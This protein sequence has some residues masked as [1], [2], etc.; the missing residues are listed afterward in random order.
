MTI[1][2]VIRGR[3]ATNLLCTRKRPTGLNDEFIA[4]RPAIHLEFE[5]NHGRTA[6]VPGYRHRRLLAE[7]SHRQEMDRGRA[8][9]RPGSPC[10][11]PPAS[12]APRRRSIS[13]R[14]KRAF[15]RRPS[16]LISPRRTQRSLVA[17]L[18]LGGFTAPGDHKVWRASD[19]DGNGIR[20]GI[21]RGHVRRID[22]GANIA[23][24]TG[25][26]VPSKISHSDSV[27]T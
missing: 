17:A 3:A 2:G 6:I 16:G 25:L 26:T 10:V 24:A 19:S 4:D 7:R 13:P 12:N 1:I 20:E 9:C 5:F 11:T 15:S 21:E 8:P 14:T 18:P 23:A 22:R 27:L